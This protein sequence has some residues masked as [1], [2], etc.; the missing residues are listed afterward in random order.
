MTDVSKNVFL[1]SP[2]LAFCVSSRKCITLHWCSRL[3]SC[4]WHFTLCSNQQLYLHNSASQAVFKFSLVMQCLLSQWNYF[5]FLLETAPFITSVIIALHLCLQPVSYVTGLDSGYTV[6]LTC[7]SFSLF[8]A[9]IISPTTLFLAA[10][11][12][13]QPRKLEHVIKVAHACLNPQEP[14]LDTKSNVSLPLGLVYFRF[15]PFSTFNFP[16]VS[17][18]HV[19]PYGCAK[20]PC[21]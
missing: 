12:E 9:Q 8:F 4:L 21:L 14:P 6:N 20:L 3:T 18:G 5:T 1:L 13:E 7:V 17:V 10:K 11:V 19:F 15:P 16:V 2:F